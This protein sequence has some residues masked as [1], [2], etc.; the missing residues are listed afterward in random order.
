M[1]HPFHFCRRL[2]NTKM[3]KVLPIAFILFCSGTG[4]FAQNNSSVGI[5]GKIDSLL[6]T[7]H[8]PNGPGLAVSVVREEQI[9]YSN[10]TGYANLEYNIPITDSTVFHIASISKQFT[11]F[12]ALLLEEQGK[13]SLDDDIK[14]YLPEYEYLPYSV[15]VRQLANHTNGFANTFELA[16]LTGIN[17]G[18]V[19][20]QRKMVEILLAQKH[21]NFEP[22][23]QYQYNNAGFSL[24]AEIIQRIS[25][26]PFAEYIREEIFLPLKMNHTLV[27][28]DLETVVSNKAYSYK[29]HGEYF[30]KVP[31]NNTVIGSS[32]VN[33]TAHD[34]SLWSMNFDSPVVG[35]S[36]IFEQMEMP[37]V[38][39]SGK[40][41]S[42]A[43]GQEVKNY[44]GLNVIFHG[45]GD[46]GYRAYLLR[47]PAHKFS[48]VVMGNFESF[49]PLD[50]S[51]GIVDLYLGE[52]QD[53]QVPEKLPQYTT[54]DLKRWE[55]DYELFPG[56]YFTIVT[57]GDTLYY[58]PFRSKEIY[59][60]PVLENK[61]FSFPYAPHSK[62]VFNNKGLDFHFSDFSYPCRKVKLS[63]PDIS[64]IN[65]FPFEGL[66]Y[67]DELQTTY[68]LAIKDNK[69]VA[70]HALNDTIRLIPLAENEFYSNQSYFGRLQFTRDGKNKVLGFKLSGQNLMNIDFIKMSPMCSV[71]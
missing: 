43:L 24:L 60:L 13:L 7:Y 49:N 10:Q 9:V 55:G 57:R 68:H 22:G 69:L 8:H 12:A 5:E 52:F 47:V 66:Y 29:K 27:S 18:D 25:G 67:N 53:E 16:K 6:Q 3:K 1:K 23:T 58:Q 4:V 45:G 59:A 42:Y 48:V 44:K 33:T 61:S 36:G 35:N 32:G 17:S 50:I 31:F 30:D 39:N 11:I 15:T 34:L 20:G 63:L 40:L 41:L 62:M 54:A 14:L 70:T 65:L 2:K 28:D 56:S 51:Y 21:L 19:M 46:A 38:L 71:E 64:D 37:S 26:R